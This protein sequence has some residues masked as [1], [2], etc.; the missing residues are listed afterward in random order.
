M[1][2]T[3][4]L[5]TLISDLAEL[6]SE[7]AMLTA[8]R[9]KMRAALSVLVEQA[10]GKVVLP[11]IGRAEIRAPVVIEAFD[12]GALLELATSLTQTG[13]GSIADEIYH[14][15]KRTARSGGLVVVMERKPHG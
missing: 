8:E 1:P 6:D 11:G 7:L 4:D 10:G 14:C 15:V 2:V 12:K 3:D 5:H 9:D 13:Y